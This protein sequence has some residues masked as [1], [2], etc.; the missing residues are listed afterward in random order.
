MSWNMRLAALI[1]D[2]DR[3]IQQLLGELA[4]LERRQGNDGALEPW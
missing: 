4:V 2:V 3:R 1:A